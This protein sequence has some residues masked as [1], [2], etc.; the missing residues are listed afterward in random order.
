MFDNRIESRIE[1]TAMIESKLMSRFGVDEFYPA[2]GVL[3]DKVNGQMV[4]YIK[5]VIPL[6]EYRLVIRPF[7]F[8]EVAN[9]KSDAYMDVGVELTKAAVYKGDHFNFKVRMGRDFDSAH[10][11]R[12]VKSCFVQAKDKG[13]FYDERLEDLT[14]EYSNELFKQY[15]FLVNTRLE[16][17]NKG[18]IQS[19]RISISQL[20]KE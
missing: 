19:M 15:G 16:I 4:N 6:N 3:F 9:N 13:A 10:I 8:I 12:H 14:N 18:E 2:L 17:D 5:Q 7:I 20:P 1:M 11:V